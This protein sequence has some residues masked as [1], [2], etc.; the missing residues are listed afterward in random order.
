MEQTQVFAIR[1]FLRE[2]GGE[3]LRR[4]YPGGGRRPY[5]PASMLGLVLWG[6]M[7]GKTWLRQLESVA[8]SDV[9]C[10]WLTG[11]ITPDHSVIGRF[12]NQ[13]S[14]ALTEVFFEKLTRRVLRRLG[15]S[16]GTVSADGTLVQAAASRYRRVRKEA[17]DQAA[18]E[19]RVRAE[20]APEDGELKKQ[21]ERAE[22][23]AR[24]V[25][26]RVKARQGQRKDA[27]QIAVEIR[28]TCGID[29][30]R[31]GGEHY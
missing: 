22:E 24:V 9:R 2:V 15:R 23:V 8:R 4:G 27:R 21:A 10:W 28:E 26:E 3:E 31:R 25:T 30:L 16:G 13:H 7:E 20:Q 1:E 17:A 19:A 11:G 14:E 18:R 12:L 5:H 29:L 6:L